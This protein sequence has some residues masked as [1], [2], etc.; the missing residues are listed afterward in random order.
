MKSAPTSVYKVGFAKVSILYRLLLSLL[1]KNYPSNQAI[2]LMNTG[3]YSPA[4]VM[5]PT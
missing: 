3:S 5:F 2:N 4:T 1:H